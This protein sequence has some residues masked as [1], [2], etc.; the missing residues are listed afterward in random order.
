MSLQGEFLS[1][2]F[3]LGQ[4]SVLQVAL[5]FFLSKFVCFHVT[6]LPSSSV[7]CIYLWICTFKKNKK[8]M[9]V[10]FWNYEKTEQHDCINVFPSLMF[11]WIITVFNLSCR[12]VRV[13]CFHFLSF[14]LLHLPHTPPPSQCVIGRDPVLWCD[15]CPHFSFNI[16]YMVILFLNLF[17]Y[18]W[19]FYDLKMNILFAILWCFWSV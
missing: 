4:E 18:F 9:Y 5:L 8:H 17:L 15:F 16:D 11:N 3:S 2:S 19:S 13:Y 12:H 7:F 6:M 1:L 14:F 10:R